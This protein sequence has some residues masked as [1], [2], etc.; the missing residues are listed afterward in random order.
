MARFALRRPTGLLALAG[1]LVVSAAALVG[2]QAPQ[3]KPSPVEE[4]TAEIVA[5]LMEKGHL[6]KPTINDDV[7]KKWFRN[8]FEMLDPLKYNFVQADIDEFRPYETKL[9]DMVKEGDLSFAKKVFD[10]FVERSNE[11]LAQVTEILREKPDYTVDES[12]VDDPKRLSWPKDSDEARE[13]L[14]KL[15][16]LDLLQKKLDGTDDAKAIEQIAIR[17]KDRNRYFKLFDM[18]EVLEVYLSAMTTV[19]DPHSSY[20]N[21]KTLEDMIGQGLHLSLEGIGASLVIEDG[22]PV[23]KEIV[24]GGAADKDGHLQVEDRIVGI[25]KDDGSREDFVE[26]KLSD[27]V[28]KIRGPKG[29]RVKLIIRPAGKTE[30]TVLELTR[31]KI[32]LVNDHAKSQVIEAKSDARERPVKVGVVRLPAFYGDTLAV[33]QGDP[34]AVSATRDVRKALDEFRKQDVEVVVVDLRGNGGGLLQE[35]ISLSGLFID[36]G[37]VVQVR[38]VTGRKHLDD[39]DEGTAW[40]GPLVVLIDKTS[41]SASEIFAGVIKDYGRGLIVGDSSTFGKGTVQS[42]VPLNEQLR[43]GSR[44]PNL[45]GLKLTIQQFYRPNGE[46]TQIQGVKPDIHIPTTRDYL[47]FGEGKSDSALGF[48]KLPALAHDLYNRVPPEL[49]AKLRERSEARRAE[50]PKF[51]EDQQFIE[52]LIARKARHEISL[53]EKTFRAETRADE[54]AAEAGKQ[55]AKDKKKGRHADAPAWDPDSHYNQEVARIVVDYVSLGDRILLAAPTRVANAGEE[56]PAQ[57]P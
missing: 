29:T 56:L 19:V 48:D 37:P 27:I 47:D 44:L 23:V 46:S 5:Q 10:R 33:L 30:E 13:R 36:Q 17:Y 52:R 51:Q 3:V 45:G 42:I 57:V 18:S 9:D 24:P 28:R 34:N 12:I 43:G 14:R 26:K 31:E 1:L 40:D 21:A 32:E 38:D 15:V 6:S 16:K 39:D 8:Y 4:V 41:A 22:Y 25:E 35:A 20:M 53:N 50:D 2:A 54:L 49:V 11:R 7:S 55:E